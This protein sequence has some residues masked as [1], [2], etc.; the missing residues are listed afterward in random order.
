MEG[1]AEDVATRWPVAAVFL[2]HRL[3]R[4]E[5]GE[6]SVVAVASAPHRGQAFEACRALIEALK[7]DVPIWKKEFFEDGSVWVGAPGECAHPATGSEA[8]PEA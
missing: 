5:V 4:I 8:A 2:H 7:A 1:I 3:G 6:I